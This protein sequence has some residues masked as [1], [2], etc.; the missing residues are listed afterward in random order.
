MKWI[1]LRCLYLHLTCNQLS[2]TPHTWALIIIIIITTTIIMFFSSLLIRISQPHDAFFFLVYSVKP[3]R[4]D[5]RFIII[6]IIIIIIFFLSEPGVV[7]QLINQNLPF[8]FLFF[9]KQNKTLLRCCIWDY[10]LST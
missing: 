9:I 4:I 3:L 10:H 5:T 8:F 2:T 6:I 1:P 7:F